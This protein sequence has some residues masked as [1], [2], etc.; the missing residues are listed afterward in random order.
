MVN[1]QN[2]GRVRD[3]DDGIDKGLTFCAQ[4]V[5]A[6]HVAGLYPRIIFIAD[7]NDGLTGMLHRAPSLTPTGMLHRA[8]S[9]APTPPL[10]LSSCPGC[11]S[12]GDRVM[13]MRASV[14]VRAGL[15]SRQDIFRLMDSRACDLGIVYKQD[16]EKEH[17]SGRHCNKMRVGTSLASSPEGVPF[18]PAVSQALSYWM[19]RALNDGTWAGI[20]R[21]SRPRNICAYQYDINTHM[22]T[23]ARHAHLS[24]AC[25]RRSVALLRRRFPWIHW[26]LSCTHGRNGFGRCDVE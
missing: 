11:S 6:Q 5:N 7:P 21:R 18:S 23:S 12:R 15:Q 3:I 13:K 1:R 19:Y 20:Q 9:L 17:D 8:P 26:S 22:R 10:S 14:R 24:R 2:Y 25:S 4:R 16:L